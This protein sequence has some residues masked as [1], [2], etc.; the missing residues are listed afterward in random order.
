MDGG[1]WKATPSVESIHL[2]YQPA[3]YFKIQAAVL[4]GYTRHLMLS[5]QA[6]L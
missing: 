4:D 6:G 1:M 2:V 3:I 5:R